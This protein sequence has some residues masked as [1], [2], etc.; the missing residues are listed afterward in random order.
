MRSIFWMVVPVRLRRALRRM[1]NS[2]LVKLKKPRMI[3]GYRDSSGKW[4]ER[5]RISDTVFLNH[6]EKIQIA[7]NVFVGH[8]SILDGSGGLEIGEGCQLAGWNGV[9][10]HSSHIAIRLYGAHYTEIPEYEKVGFKIAPVRLGKYVFLGAGAKILP[11]VTI[12]HG[13]LIGAG[14]VVTQDVEPFAIVAGNPCKMIGDTREMDQS[15]LKDP[16]LEAWY[17]EWQK[18]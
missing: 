8:Y 12:G 11:G 1:L 14:T 5:T 3:K 4:C 17:K 13:A 7:D 18:S 10:T 2:A 16:Q 9:Y 15:Y 6:P